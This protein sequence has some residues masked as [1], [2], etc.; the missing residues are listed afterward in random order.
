MRRAGRRLLLLFPAVLSLSGAAAH[1]D[2][3]ALLRAAEGADRRLSYT[4]VRTVRAGGRKGETEQRVKV[5][6][7]APDNT[8]VSYLDAVD[9]SVLLECGPGRWFYSR[10]RGGWRP[11]EWRSSPSRLDL[12]LRN[13]RVRQLGGGVVA[14]RPVVLLSVEPRHPG[15]PSKK[16]WIDPTCKMVLREEVRDSEGRLI[17]ASAFERFE[18]V[19]SLPASLFTPPAAATAAVP[20]PPLPFPPLRPRY[21][22]PG[23]QEVRRNSLKRG[24]SPGV[25]LRYTDGLGTIS[26][27][28]FRR[29]DNPDRDRFS[30]RG[31]HHWKEGRRG[32][33]WGRSDERDGRPGRLSKQIGDVHCRIIGDIAT[34]ELRKM[35][36]S[37][38]A[39]AETVRRQ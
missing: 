2:P 10:R 30:P 37:L 38:P 6:H 27:F 13:Y 15:N 39:P 8:R 36:D 24:P 26:L 20:P 17:A 16:V 32:R 14:G 4:G 29:G 33:E 34:D 1:A 3:A 25:Y 11:F 7:L 28:Q 19:R 5:W 23:Y 12:L 22:P 21:V 35:I 18:L 9:G 31:S